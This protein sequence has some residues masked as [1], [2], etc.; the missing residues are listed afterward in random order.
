[1]ELKGKKKLQW[2]ARSVD[3]QAPKQHS[4]YWV[5]PDFLHVCPGDFE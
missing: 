2:I 5:I 1:M 4:F 3:H